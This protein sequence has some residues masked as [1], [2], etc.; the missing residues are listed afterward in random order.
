MLNGRGSDISWAPLYEDKSVFTKLPLLATYVEQVKYGGL[1]PQLSW[2]GEFRDTMVLPELH[3]ALLGQVD[4]K[5]ALDDAQ[6]K[7]QEHLAKSG[8]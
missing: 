4:A 2:Y 1:R 3:A 8:M 6:R 5:T 7:A